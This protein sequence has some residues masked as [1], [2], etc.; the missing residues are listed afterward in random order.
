MRCFER[1]LGC[2]CEL[3]SEPGCTV[4]A[5]DRVCCGLVVT[6]PPTLARRC[7]RGGS[8]EPPAA[9][10]IAG[11]C[12]VISFWRSP[13]GFR[14]H[15]S[16]LAGRVGL[17]CTCETPRPT[18]VFLGTLLGLRASTLPARALRALWG[19]SVGGGRPCR[20]T[21]KADPLGLLRQMRVVRC[22]VG[23]LAAEARHRA[24]LSRSLPASLVGGFDGC[25][26]R[27]CQATPWPCR[28]WLSVRV[29]AVRAP[30]QGT[31]SV[32]RGYLCQAAG[33]VAPRCVRI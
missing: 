9:R 22:A 13:S 8:S 5:T 11:R 31:W 29:R 7:T 3:A 6:A 30:I 18:V 20:F 14:V 32:G 23:N 25:G 12:L 17:V 33:S 21:P 2:C 15:R 19:E 10:A 27:L 24:G 16:E 28:V 26:S 1:A 4:C